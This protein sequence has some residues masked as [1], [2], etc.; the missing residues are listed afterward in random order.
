MSEVPLYL[1]GL[2]GAAESF[3]EGPIARVLTAAHTLPFS[4]SSPIERERERERERE[5]EKEREG[6]REGGGGGKGCAARV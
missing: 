1:S 5:K 4:A 3:R 2:V 6:A